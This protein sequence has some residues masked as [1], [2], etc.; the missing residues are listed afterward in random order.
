MVQQQARPARPQASGWSCSSP[1]S[2]FPPHATTVDHRNRAGRCLRRC[3]AGARLRQK[4]ST[5]STL[6]EPGVKSGKV[7]RTIT[8]LARPIEDVGY[9]RVVEAFDEAASAERRSG[10]C[11]LRRRCSSL[12]VAEMWCILECW[13]CSPRNQQSGI[14]RNATSC[15][16]TMDACCL[17]SLW[18]GVLQAHAR[19][20][21]LHV[22]AWQPWMRV[23]MR[24]GR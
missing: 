5:T 20:N 12:R 10:V 23:T 16:P 11:F 1:Y 8:I 3:E 15:I 14:P 4:L 24:I 6:A 19:L 9:L 7:V 22:N 17:R 2:N 21:G 18:S 13:R